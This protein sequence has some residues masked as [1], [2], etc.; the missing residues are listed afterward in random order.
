MGETVR[1]FFTELSNDLKIVLVFVAFMGLFS[2]GMQWWFTYQVNKNIDTKLNP[3]INSINK[4][5]NDYQDGIVADI[6]KQSWKVQYNKIDV[7]QID[8]E[9]VL[10]DYA[11]L[12]DDKKDK[13]IEVDIMI[14][15]Q[16]YMKL[17]NKS[18]NAT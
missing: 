15:Q 12:D 2:G 1:K 3:V 9:R 6:R 11:K 10:S 8:L 5:S 13:L 7:K 4:L 18:N 17:K 14:I 16:Y